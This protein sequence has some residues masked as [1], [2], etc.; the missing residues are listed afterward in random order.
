M[1][2]EICCLEK[3]GALLAE[4]EAA[5]VTVHGTRFI[6]R[7]RSSGLPRLAPALLRTV[8]DIRR[9]VRGGRYDAVHTYLFL[10]D[11]LGTAGAQLAGCNGSSPAA[12]PSTPGVMV[13]PPTSTG[14]SWAPTSSRMS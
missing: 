13:P 12:G 3:T 14:W 9:L 11:L 4:T 8:G 1:E 10:A 2:V 7:R 6:F 5:G